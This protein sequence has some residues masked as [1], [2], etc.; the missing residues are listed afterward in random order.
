MD[1]DAKKRNALERL[2]WSCNQILKC[3]DKSIPIL[4]ESTLSNVRAIERNS[5]SVKDPNPLMSTMTNINLKFPITMRKDA[6]NLE[7]V[8]EDLY[9]CSDNR[10]Y[11]R[12]LCKTD[13]VQWYIHEYK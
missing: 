7:S 8:P 3:K 4:S 13:A 9:S 12:V 11:K 6:I 1:D 2:L 10:R 5:R